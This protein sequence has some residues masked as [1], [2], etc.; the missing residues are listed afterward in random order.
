MSGEALEAE[1]P[2][3][4]DTRDIAIRAETVAAS[5]Q[6]AAAAASAQAAAAT[7]T[8]SAVAS[9]A[10]ENERRLNTINGQIGRLG[11]S[12]EG[13]RDDFNRAL[14][15]EGTESGGL[16]G[17]VIELKATVT[18]AIKVAGTI[19]GV[20]VTITTGITIYELE[21]TRAAVPPSQSSAVGHVHH[22]V[23][24]RQRALSGQLL[25]VRQNP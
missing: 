1:A 6:V 16:V 20:V 11:D 24:R 7:V 23:S 8:S 21:H 17:T 2:C 4:D 3:V 22:D 15:G 14:Y 25:A 9:K 12:H 19:V 10:A 18:H 5:A 13:M